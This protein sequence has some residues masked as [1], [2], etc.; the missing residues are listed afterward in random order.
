MINQ[1]K[2]HL[3]HGQVDEFIETVPIE[4]I[5]NGSFEE[6]TDYFSELFLKLDTDSIVAHK[7][8]DSNRLLLQLPNGEFREFILYEPNTDRGS[9][10][11]RLSASYLALDKANIIRP[12]IINAQTS[13]T[14]L[15]TFLTG[16]E[17]NVGDVEFAGIQPYEVKKHIGV[18]SAIREMAD[19]FNLQIRFRIE[20]EDNQIKRYVDMAFSFGEFKGVEL[21]DENGLQN[22]RVKE[23]T[24]VITSLL[25]VAKD[26]LGNLFEV[27]VSDTSARNQYARYGS[28]LWDVFEVSESGLTQYEVQ[29]MGEKELAKR[30]KKT[31]EISSEQIDLYALTGNEYERLDL[32]DIVRIISRE[33]KPTLRLQAR[34]VGIVHSI[35][36]PTDRSLTIGEYI[37]YT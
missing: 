20:F 6:R 27:V 11:V 21:T 10:E 35:V 24:D 5:L 32:W 25:C 15:D 18:Y 17:W 19:F 23:N 2:L 9:K 30:S 8:V 28:H 12:S 34:V 1:F 37:E 7:F 36:D 14:L 13:L 3:Y 31:V 26:D 33:H 29:L 4:D 22:V 16:T